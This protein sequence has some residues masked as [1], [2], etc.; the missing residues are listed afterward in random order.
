M[1]KV[2]LAL[3]LVGFAGSSAHAGEKF[4]KKHPRRAEVNRNVRRENREINKDVKE[5]KLTAAQG[6]QDKANLKNV[7]QNEHADVK[8]NGGHLTKDQQKGLNGELKDNQNQINSQVKG[9]AA[10]SAP[11]T[12]STGN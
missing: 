7:K 10:P 2:V 12:P 8:A 4:R 9:N 3:L 6:E 5:G 11:T 1:N